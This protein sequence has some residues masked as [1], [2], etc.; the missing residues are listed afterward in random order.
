LSTFGDRSLGIGEAKTR[1][2]QEKTKMDSPCVPV[3]LPQTEKFYKVVGSEKTIQEYNARRG[4][5][6]NVDWSAF[7]VQLNQAHA[8]GTVGYR[9]GQGYS[10]ANMLEFEVDLKCYIVADE[11]MADETIS[12]EEKAN[13]LKKRFQVEGNLMEELGKQ[14][15]GLICK[16]TA[17]EWEVKEKFVDFSLFS[18]SLIPDFSFF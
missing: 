16:E 15:L 18:V 1:K 9:W 8:V 5:G 17:G 7:Y 12:G 14:T 2:K 11:F 3:A 10:E 13:R 4:K 6:R